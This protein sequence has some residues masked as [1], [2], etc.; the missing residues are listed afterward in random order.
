MLCVTEN[1]C[2]KLLYQLDLFRAIKFNPNNIEYRYKYRY[3]IQIRYQFE[4]KSLTFLNNIIKDCK[5]ERDI[6]HSLA[7]PKFLYDAKKRKWAGIPAC[8]D[9][10]RKRS[11]GS[12]VASTRE[13]HETA[14][15][16]F[17]RSAHGLS[18][19]HVEHCGC[20]I[21][22]TLAVISGLPTTDAGQ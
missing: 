13:S 12:G 19:F 10:W 22:L 11:G 4:K 6:N 15:C 17:R 3:R 14:A 5:K 8:K 1:A 7:V 18:R 20:C 9:Q 2:F 21:I 16:I